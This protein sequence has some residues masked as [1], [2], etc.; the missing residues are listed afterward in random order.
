VRRGARGNP[1]SF[2]SFQD[3]MVC[4]IGVVILVT[5]LLI[6]RIGAEA[7]EASAALRQE[8]GERERTSAIEAAYAEAAA[9]ADPNE[10]LA[11]QRA[12]LRELDRELRQLREEAEAAELALAEAVRGADLDATSAIAEELLR[13]RDQLAEEVAAIERRQRIVYLLARDE[14]FPPTVAELSAERVVVSFDQ[15]AEAS[16]ALAASDPRETATRLLELFRSRPDWRQRTLLV[17]LKPS[18]LPLY[19]ALRELVAADPRFEEVSIGLDL[20]GE[21]QW[22]SDAFPSPRA[23]EEDSP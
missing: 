13:R 20:I 10:R 21:S 7:A 11:R 18:G 9:A 3:I 23:A 8:D 12:T 6:L 4:T 1:V 2:F 5:L 16:F 14:A 19:A 15:A 17:V 22:T